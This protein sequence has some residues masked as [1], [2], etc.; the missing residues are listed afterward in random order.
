MAAAEALKAKQKTEGVTPFSMNT[1]E[2]DKEIQ[3][4]LRQ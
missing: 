2:T 1:D 3:H 4:L